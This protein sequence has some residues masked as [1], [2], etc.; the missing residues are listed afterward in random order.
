M[1]TSVSMKSMT[2]LLLWLCLSMA[3]PSVRCGTVLSMNMPGPVSHLFGMKKI[4]E[5]VAARGHTLKVNPHSSQ[6]SGCS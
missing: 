2:S 5:E 3:M 6:E 4:A 1:I